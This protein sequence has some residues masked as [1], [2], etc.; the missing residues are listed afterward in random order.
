MPDINKGYIISNHAPLWGE[1]PKLGYSLSMNKLSQAWHLTN[2][3]SE[4]VR[5]EGGREGGREGDRMRVHLDHS[6][7]PLHP[8]SLKN[9]PLLHGFV[10]L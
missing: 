4:E 3:V 9:V 2:E 5:R 10:A 6:C 7:M 1:Y 8:D